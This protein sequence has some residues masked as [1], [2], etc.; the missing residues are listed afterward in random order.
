MAYL[1]V[2]FIGEEENGEQVYFSISKDGLHYED[3]NDGK[4]ILTL[5]IGEKGI[6]DPFI[7]RGENGEGFY[8]M[9][10]ELRIANNKGWE[11][12]Q[13]RGSRNIVLSHSMDLI[14]WSKFKL[15]SVGLPEA[16]CVWA[17]EAIYDKENGIYMVF[18]SSLVKEVGEERAKHRIYAVSTKDFLTFSKAEKY[19]ERD[20]DVI[21]MTILHYDG[22]YYRYFK[23]E[24]TKRILGERGRRLHGAFERIDSTV[25]E[26]LDGVEG[27]IIFPIQ[28]GQ[29]EQDGKQW[30]LMVDQFAKGLGYMPMVTEQLDLGEFSIL[31]EMEYDMGK[32]QKR[33]GSVLVIHEKEYEE[34]CRYYLKK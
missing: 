4:P 19:M 12:A 13:Y 33:H 18:F 10:T 16:G 22:M 9:G 26:E 25:L 27:P 5:D 17:P 8:L 6:R 31:H 32:T 15:V 11:D 28:G 2:H 23:D 14:H 34:L 24:S 7:L 1:L 29:K 3:L 20:H 21:D 30:C